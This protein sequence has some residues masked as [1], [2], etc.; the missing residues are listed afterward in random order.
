MKNHANDA[1]TRTV[2]KTFEHAQIFANDEYLHKI[3]D[4]KTLDH[5]SMFS[6]L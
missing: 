3:I 5:L 6:R 1:E 4:V 2:Y